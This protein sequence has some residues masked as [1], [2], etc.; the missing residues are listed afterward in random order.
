MADDPF[1][2]RYYS[3]F[4]VEPA[5]RLD[6]Q[7]HVEHLIA[8]IVHLIEFWRY[9]LRR[10]LDVGAGTGGWGAWF[11]LHRPSVIVR[12]VDISAHAC[13]TYGHELRDI[14][15]WHDDEAH[16]L[17]V[18]NGV[19][20]YLGDDA[21]TRAIENLAAMS[22]NFLYLTTRTAEDV[23]AG[24]LDL[25]RSDPV[26]FMRPAQFYRDRLEGYFR[27]I[28]AGLWQAHTAPEQLLRLERA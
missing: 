14:S 8:G 15:A 23:A 12:G 10:V 19:L 16:D 1:D 28:G 4:Y 2:A 26:G 7:D 24:T 5:T 6:A 22:D 9:P 13:A 25:D 21:A 18:C 20:A 11:R 17:V 27:P 3:R